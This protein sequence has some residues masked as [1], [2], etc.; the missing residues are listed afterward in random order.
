MQRVGNALSSLCY[1]G[2]NHG[3]YFLT[4]PT[5]AGN[6]NQEYM[7]ELAG[8]PNQEFHVANTA[9]HAQSRAGNARSSNPGTQED[10]M[11]P[12]FAVLY[13]R[14]LATPV[15]CAHSYRG[16]AVNS[17]SAAQ[18]V[19]NAGCS[20][21]PEIQMLGG[22]TSAYFFPVHLAPRATYSRAE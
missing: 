22:D 10:I 14:W 13:W 7:L 2:M 4:L 21:S 5:L 20:N 6:P 1:P 18:P 9:R 16:L 19:G 17:C 15:R 3:P 8:N 12:I 11:L